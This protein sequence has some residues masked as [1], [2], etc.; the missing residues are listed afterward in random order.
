MLDNKQKSYDYS[1]L[2]ESFGKQKV[3]QRYTTLYEYIEAF[4]ERSNYMNQVN[5]ADSVLNQ[6]VIDYFEDIRR[7]KEF[8]LI[9]TVNSLKIHAYTAYWILRRKPLQIIKDD[10]KDVELAFVNEKLYVLICLCF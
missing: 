4:I 6:A 9:E 7:L 5:I 1:E 10:V 8:H 2:L 3:E